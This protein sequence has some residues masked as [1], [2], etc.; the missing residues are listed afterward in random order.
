MKQDIKLKLL[1][2]A[3]WWVFT[4]M[5][6]LLVMLPLYGVLNSPQFLYANALFVVIS[7][8][9]IRYIF[10]LKNTFLANF[11]VLKIIIGIACFPLFFHLL[12]LMQSFQE[13]ADREGLASFFEKMQ[14]DMPYQEQSNLMSYF[15]TEYIF[16]GVTAIISTISTPIRFLISVW[17]NYN[18]GEA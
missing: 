14:M 16:F 18:T 17:R 11:V 4:V 5:V 10:L 3:M 6:V 7:I 12:T 8:T 15:K 13:F 9:F 1:Y 2:E